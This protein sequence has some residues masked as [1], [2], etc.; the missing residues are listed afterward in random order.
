MRIAICGAG[1]FAREVAAYALEQA[2]GAADPV[3]FVPKQVE[4]G[5][6]L[7]GLPL[8]G[9]EALAEDYVLTVAVADPSLRRRI[10]AQAEALGRR[11]TRIMAD[12]ARL[13]GPVEIGEGAVLCDHAVITANARVG[14]HFHANMHSYLAHD[15]VVGDFV[16]LGPGA[17]VCGNV[18][19]EDDVAVGAGATIRQGRP[20]APLTIGRG[21]VIGM[22][23]VVTRDVAPGAVMT[24]V[25]A[26]P[27]T[28]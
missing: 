24:G 14:R 5:A 19:L 20:D 13:R 9:L 2:T 6:T 22:G 23:A 4:P 11:F 1:G 10:V 16:T 21:A 3:V 18:V 17:I 12:T 8:V 27:R 25:P 26:R 28:A 7:N 15:C